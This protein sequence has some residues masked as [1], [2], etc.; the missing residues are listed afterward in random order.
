VVGESNRQRG[1]E[2]RHCGD[3]RIHRKGTALVE[4]HG[5]AERTIK[6]APRSS[7]QVNGASSARS[8]QGRRVAPRRWRTKIVF[9]WAASQLRRG[10]LPLW[11]GYGFAIRRPTQVIDMNGSNERTMTMIA[12][13]R[14]DPVY[15][16]WPA[17]RGA[18]I[19]VIL[20]VHRGEPVVDI[21]FGELGSGIWHPSKRGVPVPLS[22]ADSLVRGLRRAIADAKRFDLLNAEYTPPRIGRR[23]RW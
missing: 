17:G 19:R 9:W 22:Q 16:S 18:E 12:N 4:A 1:V 21:R 10:C 5:E 15:A 3:P 11:P 8:C 2:P 20:T 7:D 13:E 23:T 6:R 14:D